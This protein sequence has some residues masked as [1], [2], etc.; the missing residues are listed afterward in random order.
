MKVQDLLGEY[1]YQHKQLTL[2]S[3]GTFELDA[4]VNVYESKEGVLPEDAIRFTQNTQAVIDDALLNFLVQQSGKMKPL[5]MS[6]LDSFL[7]NGW[8]LLNIGKPFTIKGVGA[9]TRKGN[10]LS[11]IQ[12]APT[13][14]KTEASGAYNLKDRTRQTEEIKEL[15]FESEVKKGNGKKVII[16]LASIIALALI[17]WAVYLAIPKNENSGSEETEIQKTDNTLTGTQQDTTSQQLKDTVL[18][19]LTSA[20]DTS[21]Q[22]ILASFKDTAEANKELAKQMSRR[23]NVTVQQKDSLYQII[24]TVNR[25]KAD[26]AIVKDSL[27]NYYKIKSKVL[28]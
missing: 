4:S 21:F 23:K 26:T 7:N 5:A 10:D 22:L 11:F 19:Q 27:M 20:A 9:L 6:D 28:Q 2:P 18:Q 25:L 1:L 15:S 14:E 16:T 13:L 17:G 24:L 3:I 8:Q 12:G